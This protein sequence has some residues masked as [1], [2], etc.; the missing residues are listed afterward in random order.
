MAVVAS[1]DLAVG[2]DRILVGISLTDGTTL[3]S[4]DTA[5][6]L[7]LSPLD[8]PTSS[9]SVPGV[10]TWILEPVIGL[11]RA[12]VELDRA[13]VWQVV[14]EPGAGDPLE[15]ALFN[16]FEEPS[17]PR[18]GA[19]APLP[20]TPT[21]DELPI[22]ELTTDSEPDLDFYELSLAEAVST[23]DPTV[24]VFSTPAFC[25][26]AACGPLLNIVKEAAPSY[27]GVNFVHVEVFTGLTE[28]DFV[29]DAAHL[30]PAVIEYQLPSEP[31]VFV[32]DG[33]G[34]ITARFEGVMD[35]SELDAALD[36]ISL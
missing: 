29:P 10:F 2:T 5:V 15:P 35:R 24:V 18:V 4:P 30:A 33:A 31:W 9:Q 12:E 17:A 22:E 25:D 6:T 11:Y 28:P 7:Q 34:V 8:E 21:L 26:T 3:A 14:V 1:G 23:G 27:D 20:P 13:G 16:V 36:K 32:I 19:V